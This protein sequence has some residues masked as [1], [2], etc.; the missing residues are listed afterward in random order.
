MATEGEAD[1][2]RTVVQVYL[3]SYQRDIWDEHANELDMS[4][5]E[6]VKAMVQAGR[7]GFGGDTVETDEDTPTT[8][9]SEDDLALEEQVLEA[10]E[11]DCLSWEELVSS[12]TDDIETRLE[13]T[14]QE[15]QEQGEVRYSG[16]K[17]GYMV[18]SSGE[19]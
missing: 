3:P 6:F 14:L 1:T 12:L 11:E 8:S 5:S 9:Q 7:R 16:P 13:S 2:S 15:L 17:G 18:E 4:R 19:R 10:L